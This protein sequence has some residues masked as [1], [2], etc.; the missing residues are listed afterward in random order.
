MKP[1]HLAAG[2]L[3]ATVATTAQAEM[4]VL[5]VYTYDS[6]VSDWGPGPV[7]EKA[8]E[9]VCDCDL[10]FVGTG[11]GAA[12]LARVKLEGARSDADVVLGLDTN[13]TAA[14]TATGL[15]APHSV[16]VA[17]DVPMEW[18]DP[19]FVPFDWGYFAFVY[20]DGIT[21]P[22]NFRELA[23]SDLKIVIQDPRSSTPGLGLL[24]WV[25]AAY[26]DEA[27][28]IW[29]GLADNIVTVTKGWSES[30]GLFLEGEADMALS[31]TTSPAYH[32]IAEEDATKKAASFS[33]GHYLQVEVAGKLAASDQPELAD[34]FL[35]F[36]VTDAFQAAIPTTNW[37]YPAVTPKDGL[38][39]GFETL[40]TPETA[41]L[42]PSDEAPA[43][44]DEALQEWLQALS[45]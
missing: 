32:L 15:F 27:P 42:V 2:V 28:E 22:K 41:L 11:D 26:G 40:I 9:E 45:K 24:M 8:F 3:A 19:N 17:F 30:Y 5:T 7:I 33:E 10:Q 29:A 43:L 6:F 34:K 13:L 38:P 14:A 12:L 44:R 39:E 20:N 25:K 37:M 18:T 21:P 16:D 1:I 4:P 35:D 23:D 31:Y 36:M